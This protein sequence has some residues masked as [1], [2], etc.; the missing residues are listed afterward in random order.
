MN[1]ISISL[2]IILAID[3]MHFNT[4]KKLMWPQRI[5][6]RRVIEAFHTI[7]YVMLIAQMQS[8]KTGTFHG[9]A[10][11]M[12]ESGTVKCVYLLCGTTD[13]ELRN[14]AMED[15]IEYNPDYYDDDNKGAF[16]VLFRQDLKKAS[17]KLKDALIIIDESHIDSNKGQEMDKFLCE[18]GI[19]LGG[20]TD[21]LIE[22]NTYILSVSATPFAEFSDYTYRDRKKSLVF[23]EPGPTYRGV[24]FYLENGLIKPT[25]DIE[26]HLDRFINIVAAKGARWNIIRVADSK[27]EKNFTSIIKAAAE[28]NGLHIKTYSYNSN[29]TTFDLKRLASAPRQSSILFIQGRLRCGKV[30]P[31]KHIGFVWE[32]S[33]DADSDT[34]L[35]SLLGRMC[36]YDYD[37]DMPVEIFINKHILKQKFVPEMKMPMNELERYVHFMKNN[38]E[39]MPRK[40][41][42]VVAKSVRVLPSMAD[43]FAAKPIWF[44]RDDWGVDTHGYSQFI[45]NIDMIRDEVERLRSDYSDE[46]FDEIMYE[47][48][49]IESSVAHIHQRWIGCHSQFAYFKSVV[50]D[51]VPSEIVRRKN[52][53]APSIVVVHTVDNGEEHDPKYDKY[54]NRVYIV[55]Q[56]NNPLI[57]GQIPL[58]SRVARTN[59]KEMFSQYLDETC[60]ATAIM[61]MGMSQDA[62][63]YSL[64]F[65]TQ[66]RYLINKWVEYKEGRSFGVKVSSTVSGLGDRFIMQFGEKKLRHIIKRI[67]CE[68][69]IHIEMTSSSHAAGTLVSKIHWTY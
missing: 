23:M 54:L 62:C 51:E 10:N 39:F 31:K 21:K 66:L 59:G 28:Y 52:G 38:G 49:M 55:F 29:A 48:D 19:V 33:A 11:H 63:K 69:G 36:G 50:E 68:Y 15:A 17:L 9:I 22:N 2:A 18:C 65:K 1:I 46:Q 13:T 6:A 64:V 30:V 16:R 32:N 20:T 5:A 3:T 41:R 27:Q 43:K 57:D 40:A 24:E 42:N 25:F 8:G 44:T 45:E 47:L 56:L 26:S 4:H 14:Q 60:D 53:T 58:R 34:I 61:G 67:E 7:H 35:Q 37:A 12:L